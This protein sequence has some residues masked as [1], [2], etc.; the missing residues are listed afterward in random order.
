[1]SDPETAD[2]GVLDAGDYSTWLAD[3]QLALRGDQPS[4]V[5]C[6]TCTA[7]CTA[8]QFIHIAPEETDTLAHIPS[9][10]LFPAPLLPRGHVLM[11]YDS[12]GHCPMLK[13]NH[14]TIYAHRPRTCRTYDCRVFAATGLEVDDDAKVLIAAQARR[15]I[16]DFPAPIDRTE[17]NA[18]R[19]ATTYLQRCGALLPDGFVPNTATQLAVLAIEVYDAFLKIDE[20]T[21][22]PCVVE[23]EPETIPV[24]LTRRRGSATPR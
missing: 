19:A 3:M 16:F 11:G 13:D 14:C 6:G 8:A 15:W 1:M 21:G 18:V 24:A 23:P 7:C 12:R 2:R 5:P 17:Y 4:N 9:E 22:E 20:H 10:L